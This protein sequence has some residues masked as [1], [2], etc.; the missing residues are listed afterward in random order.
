MK[1]QFSTTMEAMMNDL[2]KT[3]MMQQNESEN[4]CKQ[5][6]IFVSNGDVDI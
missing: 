2:M 6:G 5:Q 3:M 1:E 4:E